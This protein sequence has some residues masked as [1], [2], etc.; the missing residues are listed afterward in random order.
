MATIPTG[1]PAWTRT[2]T[3]AIYG[4]NAGKRN[5]GGI[6]AVNAKTDVTAEE[7]LRIS[8]DLARAVR[9]A[10]LFFASIAYTY[11]PPLSTSVTVQPMWTDVAT[12]DGVT[13]PT[14]LHPSFEISG[15]VATDLVVSFPGVTSFSGQWLMTIPD[16]YGVN[17]IFR[18]TGVDVAAN[19]GEHD[20]TLENDGTLLTIHD[21]STSGVITLVVY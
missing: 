14:D 19:D 5:L 12:Y 2:A 7:W 10:P 13:P 21:C 3:A 6:G 9:S 17:G 15:T 8:S 11:D 20:W 1:S 18:M 16:E 4:G